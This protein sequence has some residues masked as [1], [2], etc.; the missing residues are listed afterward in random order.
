[1]VLRFHP[2]AVSMLQET[3]AF[4]RSFTQHR[5]FPGRIPAALPEAC[6]GL[7]IVSG[8]ALCQ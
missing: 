4:G 7:P 5:F 1:L 8:A 6:A 3:Q 2:S